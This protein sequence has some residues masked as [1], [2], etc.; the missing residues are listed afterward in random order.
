[1]KK[2]MIS[3][4]LVVIFIG[5]VGFITVSEAVGRV[6]NNQMNTIEMGPR[7]G[8]YRDSRDNKQDE[9]EQKVNANEL[10]KEKVE[11]IQTE[12]QKSDDSMYD[13]RE[14]SRW[15]HMRGTNLR[16]HGRMNNSCW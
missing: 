7:H 9:L 16:N 6:E 3:A 11:D 1:M 2:K 8:H 4:S 13:R 10:T 12:W 5:I 15:K 14:T